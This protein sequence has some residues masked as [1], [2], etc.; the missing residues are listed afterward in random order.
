MKLAPVELTPVKLLSKTTLL[1]FI[2][3][4]L[5]TLIITAPATLLSPWAT[6]AS[7]GRLLLTNVSGTLWQGSATP[8]LLQKN[9]ALLPLQQMHWEIHPW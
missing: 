7:Q 5:T 8:V 2:F 3:V 6:Q 4:A 1:L 9:N